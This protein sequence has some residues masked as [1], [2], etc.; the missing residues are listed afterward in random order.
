ME[1]TA[2]PGAGDVASLPE[3]EADEP[4]EEDGVVVQVR[5]LLLFDQMLPCL[6]FPLQVMCSPCLGS[7]LACGS[8]FAAGLVQHQRMLQHRPISPTRAAQHIG[9][10]LYGVSM[11][12]ASANLII[13]HHLQS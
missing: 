1:V 3:K 2:P 9:R 7:T 10:E 11:V 6:F 13:K 8:V 5:T 4:S 12:M